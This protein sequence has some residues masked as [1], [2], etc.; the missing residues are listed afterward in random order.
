[1]QLM[2]P[3]FLVGLL[4]VG[5]PIVIHLLQLRRPQRLLFTNTAFILEVALVTVRHRNVRRWLLLLMRIMAVGA[6][7]LAFCQPFIPAQQAYTVENKLEVLVDNSLSMQRRGGHGQLSAFDE[8]VEQAR[9]I[10]KAVPVGGRLQL[11]NSG[12]ASL[13]PTAYQRALDELKLSIRNPA[14]L[15]HKQ[16]VVAERGNPL[17]LFSDFQKDMVDVKKLAEL[18]AGR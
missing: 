11:V 14:L 16:D 5:I 15:L 4:A 12:N 1:M 7:V 13:L 17:Y 10:D 18:K 2:Y 9:S 3:W 6:L 8:A